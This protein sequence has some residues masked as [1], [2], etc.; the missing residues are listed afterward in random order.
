MTAATPDRFR[1]VLVPAS[2]PFKADLTP[3]SARFNRFCAWLLDEGADGLAI[4]GTTSEANSV[5]MKDRMRM[6]EGLVESGVPAAKLLPGTG[7]CALADS[8]ELT[9]H[10]VELGCGGVLVLP[11]FYYKN[12]SEDGLYASFAEIIER[13]GDSRLQ[14]YLYHF[15]QMAGVGI[16]MGVIDRLLKAYPQTVAGLKDSS[17]DWSN[18]EAV[19]KN[20]PSLHTFP[21]SESRAVDALKIG[22]AGCISA[23]A[24]INV[25]AIRALIDVWDKPEADALNAKVSAI[26]T[27]MEGYPIIAAVKAVLAAFSGDQ[28]W[29]RV[30][31]P[32]T[33]LPAEK[34]AALV[35]ALKA[36]DFSLSMPVSEAA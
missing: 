29:N 3:D 15:P 23:S 25:R 12:A 19:I 22:G 24:N 20:F 9:R 16:P 17:G 36:E 13:V 1:G 26:R 14:L 34:Q 2:T 6:T 28:E 32:L 30:S 8:V 7:T 33:S 10:A 5:G 21:S 11:P 18:T 4:F 31:P 35:A 27:I